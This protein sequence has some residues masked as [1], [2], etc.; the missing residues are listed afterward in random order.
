MHRSF[1]A[2]QDRVKG[3]LPVLLLSGLSPLRPVLDNPI[4]QSPLEA[5]VV[6]GFF[7]FDPLV[8]EDLFALGLKLPVKGRIPEKVRAAG[9]LRAV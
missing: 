7:G 5:D 2:S 4:R 9:F 8:A 1:A 6:A 3:D